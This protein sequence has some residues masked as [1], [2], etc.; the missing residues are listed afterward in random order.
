MARESTI[1][2][3]KWVGVSAIISSIFS[4]IVTAFMNYLYKTSTTLTENTNISLYN[5]PIVLGIAGS[6]FLIS[7]YIFSKRNRNDDEKWRFFP[8]NSTD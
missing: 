3:L 8:T 1:S 6:V 7:Y 2:K 4:F 5:I